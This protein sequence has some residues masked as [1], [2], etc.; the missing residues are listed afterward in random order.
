MSEPAPVI[1]FEGV[2]VLLARCASCR[3]PEAGQAGH[4]LDQA[5]PESARWQ[6]STAGGPG[7]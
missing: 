4:F 5:C 6:L 7:R 1:V 3:L 2:C